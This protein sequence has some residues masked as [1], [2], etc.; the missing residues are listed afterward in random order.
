MQQQP[1]KG[2][3]GL[4]VAGIGCGGILVVLIGIAALGA[5]VGSPKATPSRA[6]AAAPA[7][8]AVTTP[9]PV[10]TATQPTVKPKATK[11]AASA[12]SCGPGADLIQWS[13]APGTTAIAGALGSYDSPQ[14]RR[15]GRHSTLGTLRQT[16]PTGSGYCTLAAPASDNPGYEDKYVYGSAS[17]NPP[18]PK[19]VVLAV[20]A[21]C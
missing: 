15:E 11:K 19:H 8:S 5:I 20:G 12:A 17:A 13:I 10:T 4:K 18:R 3:S 7:S 16:S 1:R 9:A 14:C 21:S 6:V 2:N